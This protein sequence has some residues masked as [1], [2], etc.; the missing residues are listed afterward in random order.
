MA[1]NDESTYIGK[2]RFGDPIYR[3]NSRRYKGY[4]V[5]IKSISNLLDNLSQIK[6]VEKQHG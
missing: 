3:F 6:Q 1:E 2:D 5:T 4:M